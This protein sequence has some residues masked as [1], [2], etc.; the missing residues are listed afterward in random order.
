MTIFEGT[1]N[2]N[3]AP[4]AGNTI[5]L[6]CYNGTE[7]AETQTG[8]SVDLDNLSTSVRA[9]ITGMWPIST[10]AT[11]AQG[12]HIELQNVGAPALGN[13]NAALLYEDSLDPG[14]AYYGFGD[15]TV[16]ILSGIAAATNRFMTFGINGTTTATEVNVQLPWPLAGAFQHVGLAYSGAAGNGTTTVVL[17]VN[18]VDSAITFSLA[19]TASA[20]ALVTN[21]ALTA[22]VAAGD[23]VSWRLSRDGAGAGG[24][25]LTLL[26]GFKA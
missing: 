6:A 17:R 20:F 7:G 3:S 21:P 26:C 13:Y 12:K 16:N 2:R 5:R 15:R 8:F 25:S 4:G 22:V 1:S 19:E 10:S 9:T 23:L 18:G 14:I 24:F 11:T